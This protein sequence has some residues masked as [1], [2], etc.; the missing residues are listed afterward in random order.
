MSEE[1]RMIYKGRVYRVVEVL[2]D[3]GTEH[4]MPMPPK[5]E[6]QPVEPEKPAETPP[7][8]APPPAEEDKGDLP[9]AA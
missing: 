4:L 5:E 3:V 8:E 2:Q 1:R 7:A 6:L 9:P